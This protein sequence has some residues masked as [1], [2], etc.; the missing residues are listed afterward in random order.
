MAL[1][2]RGGSF[3]VLDVAY[4]LDKATE[5]RVNDLARRPPEQWEASKA[6]QLFPAPEAS[7][8]GV[9]RRLLF[10]SEFPYRTPENLEVRSEGC[11]VGL[12]HALGGFGN[13]WTGSILPYGDR[14]LQ[15]WPVPKEKLFESYKNVLNYVPLSGERDDLERDFPLF[16]Q[17]FSQL[18]RSR[19]AEH[20]LSS[21]SANRDRLSEQG[22]VFGRAR[23]AVDS[24]GGESSCRYCGRCFDGCAY[25]ALF[26]P[27]LSWRKPELRDVPLHKGFYALEFAEDS[28]GVRVKAVNV[29]DGSTRLWRTKRLF[30]GAGHLATARLIARSLGRYGEKIRIQD[31]Q[32]FTF[33]LFSYKGTSDAA[34][35]TLAEAYLELRN[36]RVSDHYVHFQ[37]YGSNH[38][39]KSLLRSIV[40]RP[41]PVSPINRR[42]YLFQGF[43]HSSESAR[44]EMTV[45]RV[46]DTKDTVVV[47]G[48]ENPRSIAIARKS[49]TLLRKQLLGL[50]IIPPFHLSMVPPGRSFHTG[51]SFPMGGKHSFYHSDLL[52]RP[53]GLSRTHIVDSAAFP[54]I[55]GST[56]AFTIMAN[57]DRIVH[58][59]ES[60][61]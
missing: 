39:F 2:A 43:L 57:S 53:S 27:R 60:L 28:D 55:A 50:G 32:Y 35:L 44:L 51:G 22:I 58:A 40:P 19:Q 31:S 61:R 11:S 34:D 8:K 13:V 3:E 15:D 59:C 30:L 33:P 5:A 12:S 52:G 48:I 56:I 14:A 29:K 54:T 26:N 37:L 1:R 9:G 38:I 45:S 36:N 25:G 7:T 42:L 6:T 10:G 47:Q 24:T 17:R 21:L 46:S 20:L 49:Q 16:A 18:R 23:H 41:I 4:D